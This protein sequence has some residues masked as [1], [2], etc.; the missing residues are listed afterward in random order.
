MNAFGPYADK[1]EVPFSEFGSDGLF[2]ICGDTGAGK[3]TIFDAITFALYGEASGSTRTPESLRS[4]F[5]DPSEK[6]Y[7][8]LTFSHK[9]KIYRVKRNPRYQRPKKRGGMTAETADAALFFPDGSAVAGFRAVTEKVEELMGIDCRQFRQTS[10]IAQ[11]EFLKLLLAGSGERSEIFRRV[12]DTGVY[13]R[14]QEYFHEREQIL[15]RQ[16]EEN[17]R[18]IM[19]DVLSAQPD[20]TVFTE[21]MQERFKQENNI[22]LTEQLISRISESISADE[23]QAER[24]SE[25][26]GKTKDSIIK[27]NGK[28]KDAEQANRLIEELSKVRAH[29]EELKS[30]LPLMEKDSKRLENSG[31]AHSIVFPAQQAYMR[32]K[33]EAGRLSLTVLQLEK[34]ISTLSEHKEKLGE[35]LAAE[36]AKEPRRAELAGRISNLKEA[37]P[38]Y[39]KV[40]N[41]EKAAGQLSENAK[42]AAE[43]R[44]KSGE[45]LE[46]L[47][48]Q[49]ADD[50]EELKRLKNA[51][52][53]KVACENDNAAQKKK[54]ADLKDLLAKISEIH[55]D[56]AGLA[57][58]GKNH[59][60]AEDAFKEAGRKADGA[61]AVFLREQAGIMAQN[62][63]EREPC[64]VCGST[65]HPK[66]AQLSSGAPDEAYVRKLKAE[67]ERCRSELESI[68]LTM[69]AA[70][71]RLESNVKNLRSY[72]EGIL[73]DI[74]GCRVVGQLEA[75]AGKEL[76]MSCG[77]EAE[78]QKQLAVLQ[79]KCRR[80]ACAEARQKETS[81]LI[82]SAGHEAEKRQAEENSAREAL[83]AKQAE[84]EAMRGE[85]EFPS[86]EEAQKALLSF[87]K[88]LK[89]LK[90]A[91]ENAEQA[92]SKSESEI[93][94]SE[95]L[96][97]DSRAKLETQTAR[98]A[99]KKKIYGEKLAEAGFDSESSYAAALL[100]QEAEAGLR[101]S[102]DGYR[103]NCARTEEAA[104]QLEKSAEGKAPA[105]MD[106]LSHQL[107]QAR[108]EEKD[109]GSAFNSIS[110]R[111]SV[112]RRCA[113]RIK[114]A[115]AERKALNTEYEA[116]LDMDRTANGSLTGRARLS[117][118]EFVQAAYFSRILQQA[119]IR[120]SEMTA[121]RYI[122]LRKTEA[123]DRRVHFGLDLNVFDNYNGLPRD[124]KSLSG[125]E[126]FKASLALALGFSDV[127][128]NG[129]G[130]VRI[131]T[132]FI[133]EGFGSLDDE[134]RRQAITTLSKLAGG[135]RLVGIIS[136]VTELREQIDRQIVVRR[137]VD[138]STLK[139]VK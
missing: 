8:E 95:A 50:A 88:E 71:A 38:R 16:M 11:G 120:L 49:Q 137:C 97:S 85:L 98:Q 64:P 24:F 86:A 133:D 127:V 60:T 112:N 46:K 51:E 104:G 73:G 4:N 43:A 102:I 121:G 44:R 3:T 132:M 33:E 21:D 19:Q 115:F 53:E 12:F 116:A 41:A 39:E 27:L 94:A 66:K 45:R 109:E 35:A 32:E 119:N 40:K 25:A 101:K 103:D 65:V 1:T 130:G 79:E 18:S 47:K 91:L 117:F 90:D 110:V 136:H 81:G 58:L 105:D 111:L 96:F 106:G 139:L 54:S 59:K 57:K 6:T 10:M 84:A 83:R 70:N 99:G 36:R 74:D 17:A 2:L 92:C 69:R 128:Q 52:A 14:M 135:G 37:M 62:L 72:A 108:K 34:K 76:E 78:L 30:R 13:R 67:H 63:S 100:P 114:K 5:A 22:S 55:S 131:E 129:S 9:G 138:G 113:G 56:K 80:E 31:R 61:E 20:G 23:E 126:S 26:A 125:G 42:S 89:E 7:V 134:S 77:K 29:Y 28:I 68:S 48:K 122:F 15:S 107:L 124:V 75:K 93:S 123:D 118:E 82:E 87:E